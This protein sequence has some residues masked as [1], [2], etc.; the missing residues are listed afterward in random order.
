MAGEGS[1]RGAPGVGPGAPAGV[2]FTGTGCAV[3]V[4]G[5]R[6][7][8]DCQVTGAGA[9]GRAVVAASAGTDRVASISR[10]EVTV[11]MITIPVW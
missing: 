1:G 11:F 5:V 8:A 9:G 7:C 3:G 6:V 2:L 10:P 4:R